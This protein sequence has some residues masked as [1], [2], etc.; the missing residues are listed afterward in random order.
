[1]Q[2]REDG[3]A[4]EEREAQ[5]AAVF[6]DGGGGDGRS[7]SRAGDNDDDDNAEDPCSC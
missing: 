1:M 2:L 7:C 4:C 3:R 6:L 5:E